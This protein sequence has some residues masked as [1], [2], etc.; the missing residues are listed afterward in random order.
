MGPSLT[1][2]AWR[3]LW[4]N[5]RR[6]LLTLA[7]IAFGG[8]LAVMFTAMQ[9][10]NFADTID[11]AARLGGG[12]VAV[13]HAEYL[14]TPTL[15]RTVT[16][17]NALVEA[18]EADPGVKRAVARIQGP[19]MLGTAAQNVGGYFIA[20]DPT[21]EDAYTLH[22]IEG[23]VEGEWFTEADDRGIILG[24]KLAANLD[25]DLGDKIVF[26]M[27]D[28]EGEIVAG[29]AR[30]SATIG[31]GAPSM[32]GAI[33]LLPIDRVRE[34]LGYAPD[35]ATRVSLFV[36]D[37]RMSVEVRDRMAALTSDGVA[38]TWD[39]IQPELKDFIAMKVGGARFMELV[40]MILVA[41]SIFNTLF[42][43]VMERTREFGVL[44]AIGYS[45]GQLFRLVM[46]ESAL[47]GLVGV[48]AG[49]VVTAPIYFYMVAN[50]IDL[51]VIMAQQ[52]VEIESLEVAGAGMPTTL[53][54]GIFPENLLLIGVFVVGATLLSGIYPA[55]R[56][57]RVQPVEAINLV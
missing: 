10:R 6:T 2:L 8:F 22:L 26:T 3:N 55:W 47:L 44:L 23:L 43:S 34:L 16:G 7:S 51:K 37:S 32:D 46:M 31:T 14:D 56:A 21:R 25:A 53:N 40:I 9:D 15:T 29:M 50:P 33:F 27:I 11:Y 45:P 39:Q 24:K 35:E 57:G 12:H 54:I 5:R 49:A 38:L 41:A 30:L 48:V 28:R 17:V 42:V 18:A 19:S 1:S 52:G 4:R 20:Y 13:Q 36:E